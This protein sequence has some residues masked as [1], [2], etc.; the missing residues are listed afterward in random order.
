MEDE[1]ET[2]RQSEVP[3]KKSLTA[4]G[5]V[6]AA[7]VF[8]GLSVL[9]GLFLALKS[10]GET[11]SAERSKDKLINV[12][13]IVSAKG[14]GIGWV[15]IRGAIYDS[16]EMNPWERGGVQQWVKRIRSIAERKDVKALVI[17]INS[18]GG[19]VGAVQEIHSEIKR[20]RNELKKP[21]VAVFGDVAASG[22]YYIATACN[23]I[24]AHPGT[25]TGSIGVIF[26]TGN[27]EGLLKKI[28]FKT[29]VIKSG[30]HK[31]IGSIT[32]AMTD[33]ERKILQSVIDDAYA[34]FLDAV[35]EGRKI[36]EENLPSLAD[37]RIFT[38]R[39]A[40][41]AKLVDKLGGAKEAAALA[42]E[43]A[44]IGKNPRIIKD[45]SP[46][47]QIIS[48]LD[49]KFGGG[50]GLLNLAGSLK[51]SYPKLEYIWN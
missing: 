27:A 40:L 17:E 45:V 4:K 44:G 10:G 22:G 41:A 29:E 13:S 37:G 51:T 12:S 19:S 21:V 7:A 39:Q 26:Q 31:D 32:R 3:E 23:E 43:L 18:P 48:A 16:Q 33:E 47:D 36:P 30:K 25:L 49:S 2:N 6:K 50:E 9:A 35:R 5:W 11:K 46:W 8:Y 20:V 38:G 42:G 34:Q 14:D 24:V 28:G 1:L 15:S